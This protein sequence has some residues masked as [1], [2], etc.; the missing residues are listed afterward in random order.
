[1][2]VYEKFI[3]MKLAPKKG[4]GFK[5]IWIPG[6]LY[7]FQ[8]ILTRW[9]I[10]LGRAATFA[11]CGLGKTPMSLVWAENIVRKTN[12][13]VLIF[14][15]L[16]VAPQFVREGEK[17]GIKVHHSKDGKFIK[18]INVANYQRLHYFNPKDFT[19]LVCDESGCLKHHDSKTRQGVVDFSKDIQYILLG[20]ATPAPNDFMEL[21]NSAEVL[22]AMKYHHMLSTFFTHDSSDTGQWRLRGHAKNRFW[23]WVSSWARAIRKPSD[24]GFDDGDFI[25]PPLETQQYEVASTEPEF[26]LFRME[27]RTLAEQRQER[28][29]TIN[30][31]CEKVVELV[32]K[33]RPFIAWCSLN[34]EGDLLEK[35]IP[36]AVQ[37]KGSQ[38][39]DEK[40]EK[41][42]AFS[43]GK[44]KNLISKPKIAG[45][46]LNWQHCS[47][48]SF[49]PLHS[50]EMYYQ[51]IR[52]CYRFGQKRTVKLH[53]VTSE[54]ESLVLS[55]MQRKEK[56][57][58]ELYNGII[59]EMYNYQV[60]KS[61]G[62][63]QTKEEVLVPSWL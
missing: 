6:W 32:P 14:T 16:A 41:L 51:A 52:R 27:A 22:G 13:P 58:E 24:L 60:G 12:K 62:N 50:F 54:G 37:V 47:D 53:L 23:R 1:M 61:K 25:L 46:G 40:E 31:R 8:D 36:D 15:P 3:E 33:D 26:G 44:I 38:S 49:F 48:V 2:D 10:E 29:D 4:N 43:E 59:R 57:A 5:P 34:D 19:A 56:Q 63:H 17:F 30:A 39:I 42:F 35:L 21:G 11:D 9:T 28:R 55:N 7:G 18:G 45:F 20:T